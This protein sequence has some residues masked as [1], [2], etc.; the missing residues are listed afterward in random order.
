MTA[1]FGGSFSPVHI[2]HMEVAAGV[3]RNRLADAVMMMPCRLNPLKDGSGLM[4]DS[5][6]LDMLEK[7]VNYYKKGEDLNIW[8]D[9][10]ELRMP[11]PSYTVST[12]RILSANFPEERF[13]LIAGADSYMDFRRWRDWEELER[14]FAPIVYPRPGYDIEELRPGWTLLRG[15]RETDISSTRLRHMLARGEDVGAYMPWL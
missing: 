1:V 12:M 14:D 9:T 13:R 11:S 10:L 7:A 6:R 3:L 4:A 2:G 15:V 5:D 8:I